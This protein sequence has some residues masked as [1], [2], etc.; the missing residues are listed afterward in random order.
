M[1]EATEPVAP[2]AKKSKFAWWK[3]INLAT[4]ITLLRIAMIPLIA[5]FY[6]GAVNFYIPF[7]ANWGRLVALILFLL[8]ASTDWLDGYIA[9][10][11]NMVTNTGKLLDP[12]AD[13]LLVILGFLLILADPIW[14][15]N[16]DFLIIQSKTV[17]FSFWFAVICVFIAIARDIIMASVRTI[18]QEQGITIAADKLGKIKSVLQYIAITLYMLLAFNLNP[19][20]QFIGTGIWLDLWAFLNIFFL[21]AATILTIWSCVNYIINYARAVNKKNNQPTPTEK[22]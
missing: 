15:I 5:F 20:V 22:I 6:I 11:Y 14:Y 10:K 1:E 19:H 7:F 18:A 17:A 12:V 9:R 3:S 2:V 16:F 8:A 13:K 21:S 4:K